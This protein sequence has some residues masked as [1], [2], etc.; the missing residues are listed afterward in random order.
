MVET[1]I[2]FKAHDE[3]HVYCDSVT[4]DPAFTITIGEARK[5]LKEQYPDIQEVRVFEGRLLMWDTCPSL[6]NGRKS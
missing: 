1:Y 5:R 2:L 4:G 3:W 6:F